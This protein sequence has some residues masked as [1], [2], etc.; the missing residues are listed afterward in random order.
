MAPNNPCCDIHTLCNS[1]FTHA[2]PVAAVTH[3][4]IVVD[5]E[6]TMRL[7]KQTIF[8]LFDLKFEER[9]DPKKSEFLD[10]ET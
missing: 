5:E 10:L 1:A 8:L 7:T 3:L 6:P 2:I 4:H 9:K